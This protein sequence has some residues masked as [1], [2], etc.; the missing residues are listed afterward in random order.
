MTT[1]FP[2]QFKGSRLASWILGLFGW[3]VKFRGLPGKHGV[4]V[5]Y[6]HTSNVDFFVGILAKWAIGIEL[7]YLAKDSLFKIPL[8]GP[9][10]RYLGGRPVIRSSPQGYVDGLV[11]EMHDAPY[12]WVVITPEGTRKRTPGWR[13]GFY[14]LACKAKVPMGMAFIDYRK[15]EVGITDFF[16]AT[17]DEVEDLKTLQDYYEHKEGFHKHHMAPIVFWRPPG[18]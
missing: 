12:F 16:E 9:W 17:G 6:P 7:H 3:T 8:V 18:R 10:L 11:K 13:S 5:V 15:K 14:R 4:L 1:Q 2:V